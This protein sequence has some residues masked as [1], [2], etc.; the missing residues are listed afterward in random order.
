LLKPPLDSA[1]APEVAAFTSDP[2]P[3]ARLPLEAPH[4]GGTHHAAVTKHGYPF[5][6]ESVR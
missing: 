2:N 6:F 5:S 4:E 1:L 3:L